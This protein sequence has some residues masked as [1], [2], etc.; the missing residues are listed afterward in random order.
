MKTIIFY[1]LFVSS[2]MAKPQTPYTLQ[3]NKGKILSIPLNS[4]ID[5]VL[6]FPEEVESILGNGLTSATEMQ[7]SV[8]Y[9]QGQVNPK[10][11]VLRHL[12]AKSK[13]LMTVMIGDTA[14]VFRLEPSTH[15]ASVIYLS[16]HGLQP[17][18][19]KITRQEAA[20]KNRPISNQRQLE[21]LR[22][23]REAK[24][25]RKT[26]T[27]EY[28]GYTEKQVFYFQSKDGVR[29][30]L[31]HVSRFEHDNAIVL[32]GIIL[33]QGG[34]TKN[35]QHYLGKIKIGK[36]RLLTP[37]KLRSDKRVLLPHQTARFEAL[38][39]GG[40]LSLENEFK[41]QLTKTR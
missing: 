24:S 8:A 5:T 38:I 25:L 35:I 30:S 6:I 7:G 2:L 29:T 34:K 37:T 1:L 28:Q 4:E 40:S 12:D 31:T 15:P 14:Y 20:F 11:I 18:G 39:L 26:I 9:Q 32:R 10:A 21:L 33:N 13:V 36:S 27:N 3:L 41:L 16:K 22:L 23:A 19:K 17:P